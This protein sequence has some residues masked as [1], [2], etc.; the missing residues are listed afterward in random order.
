VLELGEAGRARRGCRCGCG[1][2]GSRGAGPRAAERAWPAAAA[3]GLWARPGRGRKRMR[4]VPGC[5]RRTPAPS[6]HLACAMNAGASA[7]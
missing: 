1:H 7:R 2:V 4:S 6:S 5:Q 3:G